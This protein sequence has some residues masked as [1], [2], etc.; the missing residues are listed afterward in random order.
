MTASTSVQKIVNT[1]QLP[2]TGS[3][4]RAELNTQVGAAL[5]QVDQGLE[6][7]LAKRTEVGS[8]L[9]AIDSADDSRSQF[10][11]ELTTSLQGLRDV[12]YAEAI[13]RMNVEMLGLQAAQ[14]AYARIAQLSLFNYL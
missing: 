13:G 6:H 1:L 10:E 12:D 7:L 14:A 11:L 3:S 2:S 4:N 5:T 9:N 8:R